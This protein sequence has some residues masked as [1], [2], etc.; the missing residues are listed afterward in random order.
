[1]LNNLE[2]KNMP[3]PL[4]VEKHQT[5]TGHRDCVYA[6]TATADGSRIFSADG[7]GMVALW[8]LQESDQGQLVAQLPKSIYALAALPTP[9]H[10]LVGHNFE[11]IHQIDWEQSKE[12]RSLKLTESAIFDL[13]LIGDHIW[14]ATG[15][16]TVVVVDFHRWTVVQRLVFSNQ[17]ARTLAY[18]PGQH[19]VAVGYSDHC[20]RVVDAQSF[21]LVKEWRAHTNSVFTLAFAPDYSYLL[22]GGRDARLK[23][24]DAHGNYAPG[25]EVVAHLFAINHIA[26]SPDGQYFVTCSMDKSIKVWSAREAR[27]LKVIDKSRHA[28]HGTSVNKLLWPTTAH[29]LISASDDRTVSV[30]NLFFNLDTTTN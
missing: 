16:G 28:G 22:S 13:K 3:A 26:F 2:D 29:Q 27:L 8:N 10:L 18:H 1:L 5:L 20:I 21:S 4:R 9:G 7:N 12:V 15:D 19:Q 17:S 14:V 30:W 11:G 23:A 6:L 24:W 25:E